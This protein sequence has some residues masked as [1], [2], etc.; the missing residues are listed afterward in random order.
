MC[1]LFR[2]SP[3]S[4]IPK[5]IRHYTSF[6][7]GFCLV[8][9]TKAGMERSAMTGIFLSGDSPNRQ[10]KTIPPLTSTLVPVM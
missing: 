3:E 9:G 1:F 2:L 6:H 5:R 7:S 10:C 8:C 4:F